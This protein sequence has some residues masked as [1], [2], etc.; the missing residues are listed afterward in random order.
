MV[1]KMYMDNSIQWTFPLC[2]KAPDFKVEWGAIYNSFEWIRA[3]DGV[4]QNPEYHAEGDVLTHTKLVCEALVNLQEW[5]SASETER[6]TLFAAA[7]FH[8]AAKPY[9]TKI[10]SEGISSPGHTLRGEIVCQERNFQR[11][12]V[13]LFRS[14]QNKGINCKDCKISWPPTEFLRETQP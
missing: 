3:M 9:C 2:P 12:W 8:D 1:N 5:Q 7:L 10:D 11:Q 14:I 13:T 4:P 6:S